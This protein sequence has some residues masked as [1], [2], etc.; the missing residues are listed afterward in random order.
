MPYLNLGLTVQMGFRRWNYQRDHGSGRGRES[1]CVTTS[2]QKLEMTRGVQNV[3]KEKKPHQ[4]KKQQI[5]GLGF[6]A[7]YMHK[8]PTDFS[9]LDEGK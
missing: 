5:M 2:I 1:H 9:V 7:R 6:A 3:K 4:T 8:T